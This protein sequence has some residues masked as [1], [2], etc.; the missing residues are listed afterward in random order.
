VDAELK[1]YLDQQ[2]AALRSE[3][4]ATEQHLTE[5]VETAER[6]FAEQVETVERRL[7]ERVEA[8]E[9][10]LTERVETVERRLTERVDAVD[11]ALRA[12]IEHEVMPELRKVA[13]GVVMLRAEMHR[14]FE[15]QERH[16]DRRAAQTEAVVSGFIR[17]VRPL[18]ER[19]SALEQRVAEIEERLQ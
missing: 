9:R 16:F 8:V 18:E 13:E 2:F 1:A 3:T 11:T 12:V 14:R 10:R 19:V 4:Q 15:E 6:R 7:T 17:R 5:Q